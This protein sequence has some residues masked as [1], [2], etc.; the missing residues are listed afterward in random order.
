MNRIPPIHLPLLVATALC[1]TSCAPMVPRRVP[2]NEADFAAYRGPGTA[3]VTGQLVVS[4]EDGMKE[5]NG[6]SVELVPVNAYTGEMVEMELGQGILLSPSV[7]AR[8]N[9]YARIVTTDGHGNFTIP[10]VPA[11]RYFI[12]GEVD[13]LPGYATDYKA[14][15][16]ME[17]ITVAPGQTLHLTL[18]HNPNHGHFI[19][20]TETLR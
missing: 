12:C 4:T 7:D 15:W 9:K 6:V 2:F 8:F 5:G 3:T 16:A 19:E 1:L 18:S 17:R 14:Q 10:A 20:T 13:W 11:G